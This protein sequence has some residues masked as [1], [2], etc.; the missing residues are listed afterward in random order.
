[1]KISYRGDYVLKIILDLS[2]VFGKGIRSIKDISKRQDIPEKF[3][4]QIITTLKRAGYVKT[5]RGAKGGVLLSKDPAEITLG[6]II[7]LVD[8]PTSPIACVSRSG[9]AS[10]DFE[11]RC[12][13][14]DVFRDIRDRVND[15]VDQTTFADMVAKARRMGEMETIDYSI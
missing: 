9:Y 4:E 11:N 2:L 6:E 13:F 10:C 14:R 5:I 3:L 1:M 8:G 12:A 15:I 7:R